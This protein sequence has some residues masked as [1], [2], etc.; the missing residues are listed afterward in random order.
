MTT[1]ILQCYF[2]FTG[3]QLKK[4]IMVKMNA[5]F[6]PAPEGWS[7]TA[8]QL[9][10]HRHP[11]LSKRINPAAVLKVTSDPNHTLNRPCFCFLAEQCG[12]KHGEHAAGKQV[13]WCVVRVRR[14]WSS[15][16]HWD[17]LETNVSQFVVLA[18]HPLQVLSAPA[19]LQRFHS[20]SF[21][22]SLCD[23]SCVF[24]LFLF[25]FCYLSQLPFPC[26]SVTSMFFFI[27]IY[28][29][30][31]SPELACASLLSLESGLQSAYLA[32]GNVCHSHVHMDAPI[33]MEAE[34]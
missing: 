6:C 33:I 30:R 9:I 2:G 3:V 29:F 18:A 27:S 23:Q 32:Y 22:S 13:K 5:S 20:F 1:T 16:V 28:W 26:P 21:S 19:A 24:L 8:R 14:F 17:A 11:K 15:W 34:P 10:L 4:M 12:N 25:S 31:F 7:Q